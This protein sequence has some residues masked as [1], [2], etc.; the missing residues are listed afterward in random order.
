MTRMSIPL[1]AD[2]TREERLVGEVG[3][4][5]LEKLPRRSH[6]LDGDQLETKLRI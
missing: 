5:L 1:T 3:I 4:V 2:E 6:Q